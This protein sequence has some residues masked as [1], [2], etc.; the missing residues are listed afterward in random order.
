MEDT[1]TQVQTKEVVKPKVKSGDYIPTVGRRKCA[2]A[3][4]RL[5]VGGTGKL[6]VNEKDWKEYFPTV[7]LQQVVAAPLKAVGMD[8]RVDITVK[9][10]GGG[11]KGQADAVKL[12][13]A[14]ALVKSDEELKKTLKSLGF[15]TRDARI[16]ERK[17]FGRHK[18]RR[19]H[20]WSKR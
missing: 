10:V 1:N 13:I 17:K 5:T 12:G 3:R 14:R 8:D 15:L 19:G 11:P 9:V 4:I 6:V 16:K 20:Q 18:A 7:E 2:S